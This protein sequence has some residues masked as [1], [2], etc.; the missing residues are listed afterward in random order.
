L[1]QRNFNTTLESYASIQ[2]AIYQYAIKW[3]TE[4]GVYIISKMVSTKKEITKEVRKGRKG[5]PLSGSD[6]KIGLD[7]CGVLRKSDMGVPHP[8]LLLTSY[9][10]S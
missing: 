7:L 2:N 9:E 10:C 6:Y 4:L 8:V 1:K 3:K 5:F